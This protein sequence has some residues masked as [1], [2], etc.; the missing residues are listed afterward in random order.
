MTKTYV[1][2]DIA[3]DQLD[4]RVSC[5]PGPWQVPHN[6]VGIAT[7]CERLAAVSPDRIVVEATGGLQIAVAGA[8]QAAGLPVAVVN[9]RHARDFARSLGQLAKTDALDARTLA[10]MAEALQPPVRPVPDAQT[11]ELQAWS[12]RRRQLVADIAREKARHHAAPPVIQA[13]IQAHL[14]ALQTALVEVDRTL[15]DLI[16]AHPVWQ[17]QATCLQSVPGVGPVLTT[18]LLAELPELG[19]LNRRQIAALVGVAPFNRDSGHYRGARRVWGGRAAVR[20][21]LYMA[22]LTAV[23]W[24]PVLRAF[25]T[26]LRA[27]GKPPKV[28]LTAAM[29]KLLTILN[30]LMRDQTYWQET[31]PNSSQA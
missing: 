9:P 27:R 12:V 20:K 7:V 31:T 28:A 1:G 23:Q 25:Y 14:D 21:V 11:R 24:N 13:L 2:I 30:A 26:Q 5:E 4:V 3:Q 15:Q 29:R 8:L 17:G 22:T 16:G 18:V 19:Q 6:E 10:R